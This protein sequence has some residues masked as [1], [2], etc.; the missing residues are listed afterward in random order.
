MGRVIGVDHGEVDDPFD[1]P[2]G[3]TPRERL[4]GWT[5]ALAPAGV[6]PTVVTTPVYEHEAFVRAGRLLLDRD[7]RP[8]GVLCFSDAVA[9]AVVQAAGDLGLQVP[10]DLSVVGFDD[11]PL[12]RRVRP[13]LTTVHQ[14]SAEKGR[15]ATAALT[16][17]IARH[18]E[19]GTGGP[20]RHVVLP[21]E[22]V[23]RD[24]TAAVPD[25]A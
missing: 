3:H 2:L 17:E 20:A 24:S 1:L 13:A 22:L 4:L 21:A 6:V 7:D 18:A 15:V 11:T 12:A 9:A 25:G 8:T 14:D 19:G 10:R 23:V 16:A 5:D